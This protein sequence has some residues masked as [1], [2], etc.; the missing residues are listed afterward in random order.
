MR[1]G[2][3]LELYI[4]YFSFFMSIFFAFILRYLKEYKNKIGRI[5]IPLIS[6]LPLFII[7]AIRYDVGTDYF[8]YINAFHRA[9]LYGI[10]CWTDEVGFYFFNRII[11]IFTENAQWVLISC[12]AIFIFFTFTHIFKDSSN[13]ELSIFLLFGTTFF[14]MSLNGVGQMTGVAILFFSIRYIE[15]REFKKFILCVLIAMQFHYS[16]V[17]FLMIYFFPKVKASKNVILL[18]VVAIFISS[19]LLTVA[20]MKI[21]SLTPYAGYFDSM[22]HMEG[23][24][25]FTISNV[26]NILILLFANFVSKNDKHLDK[27]YMHYLLALVG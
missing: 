12:A 26:I 19:P 13:P 2:E 5:V 3:N 17:L 14:F 15:K 16:C 6:G 18:M 25:L 11:G 20:A 7:C 21:I 23:L 8:G 22:Y 4:Y 9:Q 1:G 10:E 24:K 27:K